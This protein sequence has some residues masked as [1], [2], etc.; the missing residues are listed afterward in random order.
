MNHRR[1]SLLRHEK[2]PMD[3]PVT[4][5]LRDHY[6]LVIGHGRR[7]TLSSMIEA[8]QL[9][10]A[11]LFETR[12]RFLL[13]DYTNLEVNAHMS[14]AFNIVKRYETASP[15]LKQIQIAC[16]FGPSSREFVTYWKE[17]A[18]KRGFSIEI[19]ENIRSAEIWLIDQIAASPA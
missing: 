17:I 13:V 16:A 15:E 18:Q 8:S 4:F 12:K 6:L 1:V 7:D 10:F 11:K 9:I 2:R 5:E 3:A 19:F 14:E